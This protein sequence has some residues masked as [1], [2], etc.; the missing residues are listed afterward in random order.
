MIVTALSV[1][2]VVTLLEKIKELNLDGQEVLSKYSVDD[3]VRIY[4]GIGP[5]RF[6]EWFRNFLTELNEIILPA[7]LIHDLDYDLGGSLEDF[8]ASNKRLGT[9]SVKCIKEKFSK[10]SLRYWFY[11]AKVHVFV[12]IC[13]KYGKPGWNFK[14]C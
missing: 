11:L 13:N 2:D 5:D 9:N 1:P 7:A 4:N 6:P 14:S 3:I 8:Y 12:K 10:Y